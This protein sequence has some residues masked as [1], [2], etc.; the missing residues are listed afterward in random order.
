MFLLAG[1]IPGFAQLTAATH[2]RNGEG[3]ATI[4]KAQAGVGEPRIKA[5]TVSAVTVEIQ[6]H[7]FANHFALHHQ[8]DRH[9]R[10]VRRSRP[11][12]LADVGIGVERAEHRGFFQHRL[13]AAG[14]DQLANLR[15]TVQRLVAQANAVALEL[16][17]VLHIETVGRVRQ[18]HAIRRQTVWVNFDN[19]QS[20]L[21]QAQGHRLG[22]Q[23][24]AIEHHRIAVGD[25]VL[26]VGFG[27]R[28]AAVR[29]LIQGIVDA[30]TVGADKPRPHAIEQAVID[31]I[32][33]ILDPRRQASERQVRL[34]GVQRPDFAG[35]LAAQ[36]QQQLLLGTGTVA[37]QEETPVRLVENFFG[38]G[39]VEA[40]TE[41]LV[42]TMGV[43]EY[44]EKQGQAVISPGHAAVAVLEF[45][46]ADFVVGQFLDKQRV[47]LIARSVDA[48]GQT[49][50]IRA[51]A[52][53]A[54]REKTTV[55]QYIRVEQ[56]LFATFIEGQTVVRRAW[57]AV[58]P[59]VLVA[60]RGARVIQVRTPR[61][62]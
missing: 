49:L 58:V 9:L 15:R 21:A 60:R 17:A 47:N 12:A 30:V 24:D 37:V 34:V 54:Q 44:A 36:R 29:C 3:H 42:W 48:V 26:P 5:R 53:R 43:V 32:F 31:I 52:E 39:A 8:A 40:V 28:G 55:G 41:Q 62:G 19:R 4:Q 16:Q 38:S 7:G 56:Q 61:R 11:Q 50:V 1:A 51:D 2:M 22:V 35:G 27:R 10:T 18:L 46:F 23:T 45:Q 14:E 33:M 59:G 57:A 20:A 25:Q 13:F 6:R